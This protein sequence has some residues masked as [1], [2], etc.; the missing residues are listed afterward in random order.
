ME[1]VG[2]QPASGVEKSACAHSVD[3]GLKSVSGG[4]KSACADSAFS[5]ILT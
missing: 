1:G 4:E 5:R 3:V 2:F